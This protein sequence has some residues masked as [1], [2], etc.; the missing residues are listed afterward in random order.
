LVGDADDRY[1][2]VR[3]R[4]G[5]D[6]AGCFEVLPEFL[7]LAR[8]T[9]CHGLREVERDDEAQG[10]GGAGLRWEEKR[11]EERDRG[12]FLRATSGS[13]RTQ[14]RDRNRARTG[15]GTSAFWA[16]RNSK[17]EE[18]LELDIGRPPMKNPPLWRVLVLMF[19]IKRPTGLKSRPA[20][21]I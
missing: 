13:R 18:R 6:L 10:F 2:A 8:G 9:H 4:V 11:H 19:A 16:L 1:A 12:Y 5:E 15:F 3:G 7:P 17:T 20:S 21:S 14:G